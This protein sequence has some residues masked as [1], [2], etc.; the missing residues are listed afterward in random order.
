MTSTQD[1]QGLFSRGAD[2]LKQEAGSKQSK[3]ENRRVMDTGE[4]IEI[5]Q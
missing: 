5:G 4:T 1:R 2:L 3:Q